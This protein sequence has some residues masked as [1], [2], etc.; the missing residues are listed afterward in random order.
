MINHALRYEAIADMHAGGVIDHV[1]SNDKRFR[2]GVIHH[3]LSNDKRFRR[4]VINH[5]P[6]V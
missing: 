2:R 6:M 4:G 3:V 5:A 1:L